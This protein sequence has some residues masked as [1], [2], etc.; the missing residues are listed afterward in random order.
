MATAVLFPSLDEGF[1]LPVLEGFA[2]G[3]PVIA[4]DAGAIPEVAGEAAL[5][6]PA[7][8]DAALAEHI[9]AV[10]GQAD[11]RARL[12]AAGRARAMLYS[13]AVC[14]AGHQVVYREAAAA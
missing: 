13:W 9:R 12:S 3:T 1:G 7:M 4:S 10:L 5:I 6:C 14:A 2:A 11:L 8:D